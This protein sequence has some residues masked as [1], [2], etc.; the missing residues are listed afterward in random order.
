LIRQ[1]R[2]GLFKRKSKE[3]SKFKEDEKE[4]LDDLEKTR[5]YKIDLL[6]QHPNKN[7]KEILLIEKKKA[8]KGKN[9][10]KVHPLLL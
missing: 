1:S 3:L 8:K 2:I 7:I 9:K 10:N 5:K 4:R 6:K